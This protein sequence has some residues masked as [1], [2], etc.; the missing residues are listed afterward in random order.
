MKWAK[1]TDWIMKGLTGKHADGEKGAKDGH[2]QDG[3]PGGHRR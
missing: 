2:Q 1:L 3:L